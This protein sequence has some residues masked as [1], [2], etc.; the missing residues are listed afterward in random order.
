MK[1]HPDMCKLH[2]TTLYPPNDANVCYLAAKL[3]CIFRQNKGESR[4]FSHATMFGEMKEGG[5]KDKV[6]KSYFNNE[7]INF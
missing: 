5:I 3:W 1:Q 4:Y 6:E 2:R 7:Q